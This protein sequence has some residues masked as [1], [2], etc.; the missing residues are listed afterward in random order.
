[1][2]IRMMTSKDLHQTLKALLAGYRHMT[3]SL[4]RRL[5]D[6]GFQVVAGR[7]H[8]KIY[9]RFNRSRCCVISKTASDYKAG[10]NMASRLY[11][12]AIAGQDDLKAA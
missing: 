10:R 4:K 6:L 3:A 11:Q 8:I 1:M 9:W 5:N 12:L 2:G 7:K